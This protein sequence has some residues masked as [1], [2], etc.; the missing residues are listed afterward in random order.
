MAS[1]LTVRLEKTANFWISCII[2]GPGLTIF[3]TANE[4]VLFESKNEIY[5][6]KLCRRTQK[7]K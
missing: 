2:G 3:Q 1:F 6:G 7:N 4:T 5:L